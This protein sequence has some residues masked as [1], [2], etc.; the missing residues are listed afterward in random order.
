MQ[1][2]I[3]EST[4]LIVRYSI[5]RLKP[6]RRLLKVA[7]GGG[8]AANLRVFTKWGANLKKILILRAKIKGVNSVSGEKLHDFEIICPAT[9]VRSPAYGRTGLHTPKLIPSK[10]RGPSVSSV[11]QK[12]H[13]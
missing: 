13:F 2:S 8:G 1:Q 12:M 9:G 7:G 6:V 5:T 11:A 10:N 4:I 3:I